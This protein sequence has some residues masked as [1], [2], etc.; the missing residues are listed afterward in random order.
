MVKEPVGND[1][2]ARE[3][4]LSPEEWLRFHQEH[5]GPVMN[6]LQQWMKAQLAEHGTE[7]NSGL[8]KSHFL[9]AES[10]DEANVFSFAT[11]FDWC[12]ATRKKRGEF[13]QCLT[14]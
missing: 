5:S 1:A 12:P 13:F 8:G 7:P 4:E 11:G 14:R 6:E 10:L 9:L 2:L 3:Q